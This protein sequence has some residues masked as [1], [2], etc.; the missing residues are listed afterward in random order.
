MIDEHD[1]KPDA[2]VVES[3]KGRRPTPMTNPSASAVVFVDVVGPDDVPARLQAP[4]VVD[5][6][7]SMFVL[8]PG[9]NAIDGRT[10][11]A[12]VSH[13]GIAARLP[14]A[15]DVAEPGPLAGDIR[16][17]AELPRRAEKLVELIGRTYLSSGLDALEK[18]ERD[19][20]PMRGVVAEALAKQRA[21]MAKRAKPVKV[22]P[23]PKRRR[24]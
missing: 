16:V 5:L 12:A 22:E 2:P 10:W 17:L 23:E 18:S 24:G 21:V 20:G 19:A 3:R 9:I 15:D 8:F 7:G 14:A 1:T 4:L 13:P 6:S 11:A